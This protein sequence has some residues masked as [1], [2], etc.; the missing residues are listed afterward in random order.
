MRTSTFTS[1]INVEPDQAIDKKFSD[2]E[3]KASASFG[4]IAASAAKANQLMSGSVGR[5]GAAG[6]SPTQMQAQARA[7]RDVA[8]ENQTV[9]REVVNTT[10]RMNEQATAAGRARR[11]ITGLERTLRTTATTLNVVQGPLGPVAGRISALAHAVGELTGFRLG[12][13]GVGAALFAL[14]SKANQYTEIRSK[15]VPLYESQTDVNRAM[16]ESVRIAEDA[17]TALSPVVD[18]YSRL[19]L[20]GRDAGL[21]QQRIA[22]LTEIASKAAKLSGGL[23]ISQEQGLY[24]FS[25]GIGSGI[26]GGDELKSVRENT[27]RLAKA[28][29]DGLG[30]P[31]AE[32]KKLGAEGKL[33]PKVIA[34]ALEKESGRIDRELERLPETLSSASSKFQNALTTMVGESDQA[35][36]FTT[37]LAEALAF[38][39]KNLD[40]VTQAAIAGAVAFASY[41]TGK[42][43]T[44]INQ[45]TEATRKQ[46]EEV[47]AAAR[48]ELQ[49]A[50]DQRKASATRITAL[51]A[52]RAEL[53]SR[54]DADRAARQAALETARAEQMQARRGGVGFENARASKAYTTAL[55]EAKVATVN[56]SASQTRLRA[57]QAELSSATTT[58]TS[59]TTRFRAAQAAASSTAVSFGARLRGLI[60][61]INPL[62]IALSIGI[63][64]LIAWAFRQSKAA[65]ASD[66]M[67]QRE[68]NL[69]KFI[70]L[71]TGKIIEQNKAL[72]ANER[73]KAQKRASDADEEYRSA[74]R[75]LAT[76]ADS[77]SRLPLPPEAKKALRE[78]ADGRIFAPELASRLETIKA[79]YAADPKYNKGLYSG[80][81]VQYQNS[82][83]YLIGQSADVS[84]LAREQQSSAAYDRLLR[85]QGKPGDIKLANGWIDPAGA[86]ISGG[87]A[88]GGKGGKGTDGAAASRRR[89]SEAA[90]AAAK[91]EREL[92]QTLDRTDKR[93]DILARYDEEPKALDRA[94]RDARELRQMVGETMNGIAQITKE[95]PLGKGI[96][97][98]EMADADARRIEE[99]VRKPIRDLIRDQQRQ[100]DL[101][102]LILSGYE[103]EAA[104]LER[105][106]QLQDSIGKVTREEYQQLLDNERAQRRINDAIESRKRVTDLIVNQAQVA[107]D[108]FEELL[109]GGSLKDAGKQI[110]ANIQRIEVR[111]ITERLF[112]GADEK[113]RSLIQGQDGVERAVSLLEKN[114]TR[115]STGTEML[116]TATE[117]AAQRIEQ[118]TA[119]LAGTG[120]AGKLIGSPTTSSGLLGMV[121]NVTSSAVKQ[122]AKS[123]GSAVG[124]VLKGVLGVS[125]SFGVGKSSNSGS[126]LPI[127]SNDEIIVI[128]SKSVKRA[129]DAAGIGGLPSGGK[130]YDTIFSGFGDALD[131]IFK[132]D[133]FFK[134]IGGSVG[135]AFQGAGT[136]MMASSFAKALGIKQSATGAAIGGAVGNFVLPGIGGAIGGLIGGTIGGL[137]KKTPKGSTVITG[138]GDS[139]YTVSGNKAAVR[140]NLTGSAKSVQQGLQEIADQL[141]A[142][143]GAFNVSIGE[144]KGWYRVSASGSSSVGS[145]KYPKKAGSD[146]LYDGQDQGA[147]IQAAILNAIQ[148]GAIKGISEASRR[149][150]ASGQDLNK[151]LNKAL[152]I[153]SIPKRL[154]QLTDP[155]KY[156]VTTLNEEFATMIAALKEGGATAQQYA[157][158]QKLYEL[159][160]A[161]AIEQATQQATAAI[162]AF[163]DEMTGGSSSPLNKRTVYTNAQTKLDSF[164]AD[165][166]AGKS[167][168]QNELL[169]AAKNF[170]DASRALFGS[171]ANFF[172]DFESLRT[173]L[174]QARDNAGGTGVTD[175]PGSPFANDNAVQ[176]ALASLNGATNTQT[177]VLAGKLDAILQ[178]LYGG[179]GGSTGSYSPSLLLPGWGGGSTFRNVN[180]RQL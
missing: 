75:S 178:A 68:A 94:A 81:G 31:M 172:T 130:V 36:G 155:V 2:L 171:G 111:K 177:N 18:L 162:Q 113:V 128:G 78:F 141:G 133:G 121:S 116:A 54:I 59:T 49:A 61:S 156:A 135:Q 39:A 101:G 125:A 179:G 26:L 65:E 74:R 127:P 41:R 10:R 100:M 47:Q 120:G 23:A 174:T 8:R 79:K 160:R 52:E 21:S 86:D 163:L 105:A 173:L 24:Q 89:L 138:M 114:A 4:R 45:R 56:L 115:A 64:L 112:A 142:D 27:L 76:P 66:F 151:A 91:A 9:S 82:L 48:A 161:Q 72:L 103:D 6:A 62:G 55:N 90:A 80:V 63:N 71:T 12:I 44:D 35:L 88:G 108:T 13:A 95:N 73:L 34:D 146:L 132:T 175:L 1:Y 84:T 60:A 51:R 20:A 145:K 169:T 149:I 136:G 83:G 5:P 159:E 3:R 22:K 170:Q 168:D 77:S 150:L 165:I 96:Y 119:G 58:M 32:L 137:F 164:R 29:A 134:K 180:E 118:A 30:V 67:A 97:T 11:E 110:I 46:R 28:I 153:E 176:A 122:S 25:Q 167:V 152:M 70:D 154:M 38:V 98:Q 69:S 93:T 117:K 126:K 129:Q 99:G 123:S 140:E 147:A 109:M 50:T 7:L 16:R 53:R 106:L 42:L 157:D 124:T 143:I 87:A 107:R 139:G 33:T 57:I 85:G 17:R 158:A 15:L 40:L 37:A 19:T 131:G 166:A 14:T 92:Q 102:Q 148:D 104:A 144:Y 43:I